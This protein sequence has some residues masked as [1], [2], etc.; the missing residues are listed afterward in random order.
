MSRSGSSIGR[1]R[2][3]ARLKRTASMCG[4]LPWA[5]KTFAGLLG[6]LLKAAAGI[7][8]SVASA[9]L[10]N[11]VDARRGHV[12]SSLQSDRERLGVADLVVD[13]G[14]IHR[15]V[16]PVRYEPE[17]FVRSRTGRMRAQ[18]VTMFEKNVVSPS[19][20]SVQYRVPVLELGHMEREGPQVRTELRAWRALGAAPGAAADEVEEGCP[21]TLE[22]GQHVVDGIHDR[23]RLCAFAAAE[24]QGLVRRP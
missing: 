13:V 11:S 8:L 3:S 6:S 20:C 22:P 2:P 16:L 15:Q 18:R 12:E 23:H 10:A 1:E 17:D 14:E 19:A 4:D 5:Q 9:F 7:I 21:A 24:Q